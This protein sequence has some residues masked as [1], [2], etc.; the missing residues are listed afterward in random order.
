MYN[1]KE[2]L[3]SDANFIYIQGGKLTDLTVES[4]LKLEPIWM[5]VYMF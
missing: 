1:R 3:R 2:L 5:E 4:A